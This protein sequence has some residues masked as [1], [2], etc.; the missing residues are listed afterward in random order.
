MSKWVNNI[1]KAGQ[2]NRG[3]V[4]RRDIGWVN[5]Q[6][7]MTELAHEVE[8]RGFKMVRVGDQV[9]ILCNQNGVIQILP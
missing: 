7:S 9:I 3:N 2:A 1:F 5:Q 4:V 6:A 8:R